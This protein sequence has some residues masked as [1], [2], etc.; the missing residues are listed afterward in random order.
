MRLAALHD[1]ATCAVLQF[2]DAGDVARIVAPTCRRLRD[3]GRSDALLMLRRAS[4]YHLRGDHGVV[5]ALATRMGTRPW[6]MAPIGLEPLLAMDNIQPLAPQPPPELLVRVHRVYPSGSH[7]E[8]LSQRGDDENEAI[9]RRNHR[10]A[11]VAPPVSNDDDHLDLRSAFGARGREC[12]LLEGSFVSYHLPCL[13]QVCAFRLSFGS[14]SACE[15][16]NWSFQ[17]YYDEKQYWV[18]LYQG[19]V[20]PWPSYDDGPVQRHYRHYMPARKIV[21]DAEFASDQYRIILRGAKTCMHIRAFE[22]FG[23][24]SAGWDLDQTPPSSESDTAAYVDQ[25]HF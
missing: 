19:D 9:G 14:C 15:S 3:L 1:D 25:W 8:E 18:T 17:A 22:V 24:M 4:D 10:W 21:V 11:L 5:H 16:K 20:S 23:T 6:P 12:S 13:I 2:V 7:W